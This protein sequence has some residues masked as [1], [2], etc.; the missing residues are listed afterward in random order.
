MPTKLHQD[1]NDRIWA[2]SYAALTRRHVG[3]P[4]ALASLELVC[5]KWTREPD[6]LIETFKVVS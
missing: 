3:H 1:S 2:C 5:G 6:S 4:D